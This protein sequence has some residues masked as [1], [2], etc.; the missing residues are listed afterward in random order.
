MLATI[1]DQQDVLD[2]AHRR[3]DEQ[4][5]FSSAQLA[6][7]TRSHEARLAHEVLQAKTQINMTNEQARASE[8]GQSSITPPRTN[9]MGGD[10]DQ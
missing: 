3:Y 7:L 4:V 9:A 1:C 5:K 2:E 8:R 10:A 6:Q